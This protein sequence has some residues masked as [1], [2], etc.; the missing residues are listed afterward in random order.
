MATDPDRWALFRIWINLNAPDRNRSERQVFHE[1]A[2]FTLGVRF[3]SDPAELRAW[4]RT[5]PRYELPDKDQAKYD[6]FDHANRQLTKRPKLRDEWTV[7]DIVDHPENA[8][9]FD[10]AGIPPDD[11]LRG[12]HGKLERAMRTAVERLRRKYHRREADID[13]WAPQQRH[14]R[15]KDI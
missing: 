6:W 3:V 12:E 5:H 9:A 4:L 11:V 15:L 1:A 14:K 8:R 2:A 7:Q 13:D 10:A